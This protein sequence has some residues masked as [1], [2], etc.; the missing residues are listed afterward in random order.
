MHL[1]NGHGA[2]MW[3]R[4]CPLLQPLVIGPL[5]GCVG[6]DGG[7]GRGNFGGPRHGV[8]FLEPVAIWP[9]DF[10]LVAGTYLNIRDE[11]FPDSGSSQRTHSAAV[12]IPVVEVANYTHR[13][14]IWCP[15]CEG[16]AVDVSHFARIVLPVRTKNLP[17]LFVAT[18]LEQV[19]VH[20]A[21]SG[22]ETVG[23]IHRGHRVAIAN[24]DSVI[25]HGRSGNDGGPDTALF[26]LRW[27]LP[28]RG[29]NGHLI[30]EMT[31]SSDGYR[32]L[33]G[34]P[35]QNGVG[36]VVMAVRNGL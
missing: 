17:Q 7:G 9:L 30:G 4:F 25:G 22:K 19:K 14:R 13:A 26:M 10:K 20:F 16:N 12:A 5:I 8:S 2:L 3:V 21:Q 18:F 28:V 29:H 36:G 27:E 32:I 6:D 34:V 33:A 24:L 15:N 35:T 23:I 11:Q 31:N 1:V